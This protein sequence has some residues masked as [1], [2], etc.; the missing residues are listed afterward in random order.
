MDDL[1]GLRP[2]LTTSQGVV[3]KQPLHAIRRAYEGAML[4]PTS[5]GL[6]EQVYVLWMNLS[7]YFCVG[8][9]CL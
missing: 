2:L 6:D 8:V 5:D 4:A 7:S 3:H 1:D 9:L